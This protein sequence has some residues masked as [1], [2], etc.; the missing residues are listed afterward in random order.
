MNRVLI[1]EDDPAIV[2]GLTALLESENYS[3]L[4]ASDGESGLSIALEKEPELILLDVVLPKLNGLEVLK[5]LRQKGSNRTPIIM[6][7]SKKDEIDRVMG[8]EFGADDYVTK[9]FS[10]RE[11]IA[12]I[13]AVLRRAQ[14][15]GNGQERVTFGDVTIDNK[16]RE[17]TKAG[18]VLKFSVT[19]YKLLCYFVKHAGEVIS[20]DTLLDAVWGYDTY[21]TTRTVDNFIL[22]LRKQIEDD[23]ASPVHLRTVH[24]V[25]YKFVL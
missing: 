18:R 22:M 1:I 17:I 16:H 19:E 14:P 5:N 4:T 23:P 24:K 6:L 25:G 11:L 3:T 21:P 9:P 15:E 20:R 13:K 8:L 12:R 10:T 7:T 2:K